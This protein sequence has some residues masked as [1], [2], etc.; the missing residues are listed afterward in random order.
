MQY[1]AVNAKVRAMKSRLLTSENYEELSRCASVYELGL[2]LKEIPEYAK[3]LK[4]LE[5]KDLIRTKIEPRL[6]MSLINEFSKIYKFVG[7]FNIKKYLDTFILENEIR[8][9]KLLLCT[10]YD[11]SD[12]ID[13]LNGTRF[14][15]LLN[16][17]Y[18]NGASLF[19]MTTILD[20]YYHVELCKA[21]NKY[22]RGDNLRGMK[23]INGCDI[24]L[25][26]LM[27]LYRLKIF[28]NLEEH[29][30]YSY[31]IPIYYKLSVSQIEKIIQAKTVQ[32]V[33]SEIF[34]TKY[35]EQLFNST[36]LES[37][38]VA[39]L[40]NTYKN[41]ETHYRN[42]IVPIVAYMFYK[43]TEIRNVISLL[44]G[45]KYGLKSEEILMTLR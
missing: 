22:L 42:S 41:T 28:Y 43:N 8:E 24:D 17:A 9:L 10:A 5:E 20:I 32:E 40:R 7:D 21:Q 2:K 18:E 36:K 33:E 31:I 26:N 19:E 35:G 30:I 13:S 23:S 27:W 11:K 37:N 6:T 44:E 25:K 45:V 3:E 15:H 34:N 38:Y 29:K 14:H 1:N 4:E 39:V 16:V 12:F